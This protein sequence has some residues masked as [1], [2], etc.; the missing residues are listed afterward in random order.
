MNKTILGI[1]TAGEVLGVALSKGEKLVAERYIDCG[2]KHSVNLMKAIEG[3]LRDAD[4]DIGD[5]DVFAVV[6]GPGSFTGI[7]IGVCTAKAFCDATDKKG[8]A[9]NALDAL[10]A[11]NKGISTCAMIDARNEQV[12]ASFYDEDAECVIR[13]FAGDIRDV[14]HMLEGRVLFVGSGAGKY[15]KIIEQYCEDALFL[16]EQLSLSRAANACA[17]ANISEDKYVNCEEILPIY[18]RESGAVRQKN[19]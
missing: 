13:D 19:V 2:L 3:C 11:S 17:I 8:I 6:A 1:D 9:I 18:V 15:R 7:R 5:V 14:L 12:Y 10:A 16:P 4:T